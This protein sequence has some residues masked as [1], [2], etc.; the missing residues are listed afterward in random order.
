LFNGDFDIGENSHALVSR[1]H[2]HLLL[3]MFGVSGQFIAPDDTYYTNKHNS[4]VE[5]G[6]QWK[7]F[8]GALEKTPKPPLVFG[9]KYA[10]QKQTELEKILTT[11]DKR[12]ENKNTRQKSNATEPPL[13]QR[14]A[15]LLEHAEK[16][17]QI[18][19]AEHAEKE[20]L[21]SEANELRQ[22][23]ETAHETLKLTLA[24]KNAATAKSASTTTALDKANSAL[25]NAEKLANELRRNLETSHETLKLTLA[26]KN[27]A[28]A[29]L[30]STATALDKANSALENAA[31]L[32]ALADQEHQKLRTRAAAVATE[33][34]DAQTKIA[35]QERANATLTQ[36]LFNAK[37]EI[38]ENTKKL[39]EK[40]TELQ[41]AADAHKI[42]FAALEM[43][44][45]QL[46]LRLMT[47]EQLI[48][49]YH[50]MS[51]DFFISSYRKL[52]RT[53]GI[54]EY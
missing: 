3:A 1:F 17:E 20:R 5:Q 26:E 50:K 51:K 14:V 53:L 25:E 6:S 34:D 32:A 48:K 24:E 52:R 18:A 49:N 7:R 39:H 43:S 29:K 11:L 42:T 44:R 2:L 9:A 47:A 13:R 27:A 31:K 30:A 28:T 38:A 21:S 46:L 37:H 36:E 10:T 12:I 16:Q 22:N 19:R 40:E 54:W 4:L 8:T 45:N 33:R 15:Q 41:R 23:L 35:Q